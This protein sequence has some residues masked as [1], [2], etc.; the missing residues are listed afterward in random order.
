[1]TYCLHKGRKR[2][3][4]TKNK[5]IAEVLPQMNILTLETANEIPYSIGEFW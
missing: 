3:H 4:S 5:P 2:Q 1:M